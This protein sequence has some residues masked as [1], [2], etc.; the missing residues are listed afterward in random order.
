MNHT[1]SKGNA[2]SIQ[3]HSYI[4]DDDANKFFED[5]F[6]DKHPNRLRTKWLNSNPVRKELANL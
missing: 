4:F 2:S 6:R 1:D 3:W 5:F